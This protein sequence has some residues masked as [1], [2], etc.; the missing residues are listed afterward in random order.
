VIE[1]QNIT[2]EFVRHIPSGQ[3]FVIGRAA[4]GRIIGSA[5]PIAEDCIL[6][7]AA[8]TLKTGRNGWL[9]QEKDNLLQLEALLYG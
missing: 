8:Y 2:R 4:S 5:G 3:I 9:Q 6:H 1:F 7:P